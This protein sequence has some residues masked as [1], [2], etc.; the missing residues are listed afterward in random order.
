MPCADRYKCLVYSFCVKKNWFYNI[1]YARNKELK[2][3]E[4]KK[5]KEKEPRHIYTNTFRS[6]KIY[7]W[8]ISLFL[9]SSWH[10]LVNLTFKAATH[11]NINVFFVFLLV[12]QYFTHIE[13]L[14]FQWSALLLFDL[15]FSSISFHELHCNTYSVSLSVQSYMLCQCLYIILWASTELDKQCACTFLQMLV[16]YRA[17]KS[18]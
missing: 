11:P 3:N 12:R 15:S 2:Y 1:F 7:L 10:Q 14:F 18:D 6:S 17:L 13:K 8:L 9:R 4:A 5:N 16:Y